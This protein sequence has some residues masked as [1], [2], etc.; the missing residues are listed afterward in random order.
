MIKKIAIDQLLPG[1]FVHDLNCGWLDHPFLK[2][3]FPVRDQ[4]TIEKIRAIGIRELYIDTI[5][6]ADVFAARTQQEVSED[7]DRLLREIASRDDDK[8]IAAELK[9]EA[10]RARRLHG[11]ANRLARNLMGDLRLGMPVEPEKFAPVVDGLVDSVFRNSDAL[12][13]LTRLK[14]QDSYTF[15]HSVGVCTLLAAFGRS[16]GLPRDEIREIALGGLL[17]DVGKAQVDDAIVDKPGKLSEEEFAEMKAHVAKGLVILRAVPDLSATALSVVAEHHERIDGSGY[18]ACKKGAQLSRAGQMA[19]IV[20]VYDAMCSDRVYH[21]GMAP[22]PALRKLL[23]WSEHHFDRALVQAFIRALG[24]YPTGSLVRLDSGRLGVVVEQNE[25]QILEPVVRV[26]YHAGK[27][28]YI[29]P[30]TVDLSRTQ[31]RIAGFENYEKWNIDPYKWL[32]A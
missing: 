5:K 14:S 15:E 31:D 2:S 24:I 8:P 29:P 9:E 26:F 11:E 1:M 32:P 3:K 16:L 19:A 7:L 10:A 21:K 23:E 17:H 12:L 13:P 20:D 27:Q 28:Y 18:P 30:E 22:T 25:R 4:A 6:G